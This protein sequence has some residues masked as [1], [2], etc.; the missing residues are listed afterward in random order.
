VLAVAFQVGVLGLFIAATGVT[1]LFGLIWVPRWLWG[2]VRRAPRIGVRAWPLL[3]S[4]ALVCVIAIA[5]ASDE[6]AIER[7]GTVTVWSVGIFLATL[8]YPVAS[9]LGLAT[10]WRTPEAVVG[11]VLRNYA[12]AAGTLNVLVALYLTWWRVIGWRTWA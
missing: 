8:V 12:L 9:V 7:L 4:L 5:A 3:A 1:L 11:R 2:K 10:A 6:D